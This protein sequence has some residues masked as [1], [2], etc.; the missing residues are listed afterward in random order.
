MA[1]EHVA[2][3]HVFIIRH[4]NNVQVSSLSG[5]LLFLYLGCNHNSNHTNIWTDDTLMYLGRQCILVLL[6]IHVQLIY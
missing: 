2:H 5:L 1:M 6:A 4:K 3:V